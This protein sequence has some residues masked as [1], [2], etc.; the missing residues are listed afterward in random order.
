MRAAR[1]A[2]IETIELIDVPEPM[3]DPGDALVRVAACGICG[4][5]LH[6]YKLGAHI[7]VGQIMGHEFAGV[8]VALGPGADPQRIVWGR[9]L[10]PLGGAASKQ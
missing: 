10:M 2:G 6:S 5:D 8:V 4:T 7:D 9:P 1:F 3:P